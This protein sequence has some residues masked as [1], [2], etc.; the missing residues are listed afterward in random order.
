MSR[1]KKPVKMDGTHRIIA[2]GLKPCTA[3]EKYIQR[4]EIQMRNALLKLRFLYL[5]RIMGYFNKTH[6]VKQAVKTSINNSKN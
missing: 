4:T 6:E 1:V 2:I 3:V 5:D